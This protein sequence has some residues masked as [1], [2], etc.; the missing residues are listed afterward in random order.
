MTFTCAI[1][2][3][4]QAPIGYHYG[5]LGKHGTPSYEFQ[6]RHRGY[7]RTHRVKPLLLR[8]GCFRIARALSG[9]SLAYGLFAP[10]SKLQMWWNLPR[11]EDGT[12]MPRTGLFV[13]ASIANGVWT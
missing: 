8:T 11:Q 6:N 4:Y 9:R 1:A 2:K 10:L 12:L 5:R 7:C 13:E 3:G